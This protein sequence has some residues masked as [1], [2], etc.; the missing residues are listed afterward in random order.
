[1]PFFGVFKSAMDVTD[2]ATMDV[3]AATLALRR[4]STGQPV[5][6]SIE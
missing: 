6:G 3:G 2:P 4:L 1:M 5:S